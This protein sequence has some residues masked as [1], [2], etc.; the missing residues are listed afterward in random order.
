MATYGNTGGSGL[1]INVYSGSGGNLNEWALDYDGLKL[2]T[3][4][5]VITASS[6][7]T[8]Q[9]VTVTLKAKP[10]F[11][12]I[13]VSFFRVKLP[14][15][16]IQEYPAINNTAIFTIPIAGALGSQQTLLVYAR[17]NSGNRSAVAS[18][19][20]T[21]V[22]SLPPSVSNITHNIPSSFSAGDVKQIQISGAVDPEGDPYTYS[23]ILPPEI[24]GSKI[25]G[26]ANNETVTLTVQNT[27]EYTKKDNIVIRVTDINGAQDDKVLDITLLSGGSSGGTNNF[28]VR[29][30]FPSSVYPNEVFTAKIWELGNNNYTYGLNLPSSV[31]A[32]KTM[33]ILSNENFTV[34]IAPNVAPNSTIGIDVVVYTGN[35][36]VSIS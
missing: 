5:E 32:S 7:T 34:T 18:H 22:N 33:G 17:D 24:S 27:I 12:N 35:V 2:L 28:N 1:N 25:S 16:V 11:N 36:C 26:I 10:I 30:S 8:N 21:V 9:S 15:G 6:I 19:L 14:D 20:Y 13:S 3:I 23:L 31:T 29:T 4:P